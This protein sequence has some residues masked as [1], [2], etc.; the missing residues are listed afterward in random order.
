MRVAQRRVGG[1]VI[2]AQEWWHTA[3][4]EEHLDNGGTAVA[5]W[6]RG[7][8]TVTVEMT[9]MLPDCRWGRAFC[10]VTGTSLALFFGMQRCVQI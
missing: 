5:H 9:G 10:L 7:G 1:M 6:Q 3:D 4:R 2:M 8:G